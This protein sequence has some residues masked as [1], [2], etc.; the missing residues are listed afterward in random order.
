MTDHSTSFFVPVIKTGN[1]DSYTFSVLI[2]TYNN[3]EHLHLLLK[4]I[5]LNSTYNH[6]VIIIV[7]EGIDGTAEWVKGV[8][9]VD[10]V[11]CKV[12]TGICFA[13]NFARSLVK[14]EY[15]VY[16]NDDMYLMPEWDRVFLEEIKKIGHNYFFLSGTMIEPKDTGNTCVIVGDYGDSVSSFREDALL[17][18]NTALVKNDWLGATWPPNILHRDL[19]D[20]AG[21]YSIE[22]SPGM[23]SDPDLSMKLW[24]AGVRVFKGLGHSR[25]YHFGSKTTGRVKVNDGAYLFFLKWGITSGA[26]TSKILQRGTEI[27][28]RPVNQPAYRPGALKNFIKKFQAFMKFQ[29]GYF[30]EFFNRFK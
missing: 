5:R 25:V 22:F 23:Y 7:N 24:L 21:G 1:P 19:W 3:L 27:G 2:P 18:S 4:S 28:S 10:A 17:K 6:Q 26:F 15:I 30:N 8:A 16:L 11:L 13:L 29:G 20:L 12:N 9:D 14:T